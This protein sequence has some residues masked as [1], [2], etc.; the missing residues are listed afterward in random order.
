MISLKELDQ[1]PELWQ[2]L[3]KNEQAQL[4][5]SMLE[6]GNIKLAK[7]IIQRIPRNKKNVKGIL[8]VLIA[9][10]SGGAERTCI[11]LTNRLSNSY[12]VGI[13]YSDETKVKYET[14]E[15]ILLSHV[16][17]N[18]SV[19]YQ[20][21]F[22]FCDKNGFD[23]VVLPNHWLRQNFKDIY[24]FKL[25]G[26]RVIAQE[27]NV[28]FYPFY[29]KLDLGLFRIRQDAYEVVDCLTCLSGMDE[30]IWKLAG[31]KHALYMPNMV[32]LTTQLTDYEAREDAVLVLSR[33]TLLKGLDRLPTIIDNVLKVQPTAKFY[34]VGSFPKRQQKILFQFWLRL[35]L[36]KKY[37]QVVFVDFTNDVSDYLRK[38]KCL[39]IPSYV[40]GSPMVISEARFHGTP[41]V[42][43]GKTYI[44]NAKH[45]VVHLSEANKDDASATILELLNKKKYWNQISQESLIGLDYWGTDSVLKRWKDL[46]ASFEDE[47]GK[48]FEKS[49]VFAD[50]NR[51]NL[52]NII[53][54]M[55]SVIDFLDSHKLIA[56]G[57]FSKRVIRKLRRKGIGSLF[58]SEGSKSNSASSNGG[59]ALWPMIESL[60]ILSSYCLIT[61][62]TYLINLDRSVERLK[63]MN[64]KAQA[65][66]ISFERVKAVDGGKLDNL[67]NYCQVPNNHYPYVLTAGEV[68]CFLSHRKCWEKLVESSQDWAL[69]LED[70][71]IFSARATPY[72]S[73]TDWIPAGVDLIQLFY[74]QHE[75]V[76]KE[77]LPLKD[78]NEL[79]KL[80][81]SSPVGSF[82]YFISRTA[83]IKALS[84]SSVVQ[85]P[86]D[87]FL[88]GD[89]FEFKKYF[90]TW[91]LKFGVVRVDDLTTTIIGRSNKSQKLN[92]Y[93]LS[94]S[95]F[96]AK[97][98]QKYRRKK[99]MHM[100]QVWNG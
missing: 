42:I 13:V 30:A 7:K 1:S 22:Q 56:W 75:T 57:W 25:L 88:H 36:K 45:G 69:I 12:K 97:L 67:E 4:A 47:D 40:E 82:A 73:N 44:D 78:G 79:L 31:I 76:Y 27:H 39:L 19:R 2:S 51:D 16:S 14:S 46:F 85:G 77:S 58:N 21:I 87:N 83:A 65:I 80:D 99:L 11:H 54:E 89:Y 72:L 18:S 10:S 35:K 5:A 63:D 8:F 95:R 91:R 71:C 24:W 48:A 62:K 6:I 20:E 66:G 3:N 15:K 9:L 100:H 61:M 90:P 98:G 60:T 96:I 33:M 92:F 37:K 49:I 43:F 38:V 64:S 29:D 74:T 53:G 23:T 32:A 86:V 68:A 17:L 34:L 70:D 59:G 26:L 41:V 55:Y 52:K 84:L 81:C 28:F 93:R 50:G 94:P